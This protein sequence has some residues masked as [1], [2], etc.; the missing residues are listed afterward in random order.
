[1]NKCQEILATGH[2]EREIFSLCI[3]DADKMFLS[4]HDRSRKTDF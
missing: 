1:M 2:F 4:T 3:P